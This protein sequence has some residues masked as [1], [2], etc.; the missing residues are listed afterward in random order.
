MIA[1]ADETDSNRIYEFGKNIGIAFQLHDDLLDVYGDE[2][3]FGKQTGGDII[4]N[5]KTFLLLKALEQATGKNLSV[6]KRWLSLKSFDAQEKV[7]AIKEIFSSLKIRE[8]SELKTDSYFQKALQALDQINVPEEN[9]S[10]LKNAA[11]VLM[12]REV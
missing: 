9:K 5:K 4:A 2:N 7:T 3:K 8:A 11:G 1:G 10:A 12:V 6:L